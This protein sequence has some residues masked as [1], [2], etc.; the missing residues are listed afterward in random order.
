MLAPSLKEVGNNDNALSH[1]PKMEGWLQTGY[2]IEFVD[3]SI[4]LS[5]FSLCVSLSL[6]VSLCVSLSLS[7]PFS[8]LSRAEVCLVR[9]RCRNGG[10]VRGVP[11]DSSLGAGPLPPQHPLQPDA[12]L[13]GAT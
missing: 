12:P 6:S 4:F 10:A 5:P 9:Q 7:L 11:G 1:S 8:L 13:V 2:L 3:T